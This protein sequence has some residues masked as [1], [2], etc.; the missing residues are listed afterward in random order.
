[1]ALRDRIHIEVHQ[2]ITER[3]AGW[4]KQ[5]ADLLASAANVNAKVAELDA[6][7]TEA[8]RELAT[9]ATKVPRA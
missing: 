9:A 8:E 5:R 4:R 1:M 2:L 6:A 3:L 7:I